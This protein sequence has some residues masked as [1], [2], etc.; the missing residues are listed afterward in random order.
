[1]SKEK[2]T[3]KFIS[4]YGPKKFGSNAFCHE[5]DMTDQR[6]PLNEI[7]ELWNTFMD[8]ED[9]MDELEDEKVE[10]FDE[11]VYEYEDISEYGEDVLTASQPVIAKY[12]PKRSK[13]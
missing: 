10:D 2:T 1:M 4:Q 11:D 8:A 3:S 12:K 9:V 6:A 5:M 13:K 7:S